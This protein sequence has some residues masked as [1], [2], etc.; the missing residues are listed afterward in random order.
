MGTVVTLPHPLLLVGLL[1]ALVGAQQHPNA[2]GC[3]GMYREHHHRARF[4]GLHTD[5]WTC[6]G[7][8]NTKCH[9]WN[10]HGV[11]SGGLISNEMLA[12][13][14]KEPGCGAAYLEL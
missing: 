6:G 8:F 12:E 11:Q 5:E 2:S 14:A 1:A 7:A 3:C 10:D 13:M 4:C 9:D